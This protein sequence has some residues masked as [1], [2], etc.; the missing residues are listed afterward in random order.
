MRAV[1]KASAVVAIAATL[2]AG[3]PSSPVLAQAG[4]V[5]INGMPTGPVDPATLISSTINAFPN[6]GEPLKLA[7]SDLIVRH[8]ELAASLAAYLKN[9]PDLT[10]DQREAA[11]TGLADALNRL[12]I[13]A[14]AAS[15]IDPLT[16]AIIAGLA[17][18]G[19]VGIAYAAK[20]NTT[21]PCTVSCN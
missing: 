8:P 2:A 6:G 11:L 9:D 12:G 13:V 18:A 16:L 15:G 14:Q 17:A 19:A 21:T 5:P 1:Q 4:V 7:I 3:F 20:N 10:P